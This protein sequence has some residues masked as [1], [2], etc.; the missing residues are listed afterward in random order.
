MKPLASCIPP[1]QVDAHSKTGLARLWQGQWKILRGEI[2]ERKPEYPE[3][4]RGPRALREAVREGKYSE[5][6]LKE[7]F[8]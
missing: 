4:E 6:I 7:M 1:P 5:E 2:S 8:T 3:A